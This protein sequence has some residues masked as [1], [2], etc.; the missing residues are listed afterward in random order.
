MIPKNE[1]PAA[2]TR[3]VE[4]AVA[5]M[6]AELEGFRASYGSGW[7]RFAFAR[8][9]LDLTAGE[10]AEVLKAFREAGYHCRRHPRGGHVI[11]C[12]QNSYDEYEF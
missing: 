8:T 1:C 4:E 3:R 2:D 12:V 5:S 10:T 11:S 6:V 7:R 9:P